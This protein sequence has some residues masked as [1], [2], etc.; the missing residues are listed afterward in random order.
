MR[1]LILITLTTLITLTNVSYASFPVAE[2]IQTEIVENVAIINAPESSVYML[3]G[4]FVGFFSW[5]LVL[6]PLLLLFIPNKSFRQGIIAGFLAMLIL[7][8][9]IFWGEIFGYP[10]RN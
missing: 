3:L 9:L 5:V 2:N 1:K 7:L 6:L 4:F 8:V 10:N